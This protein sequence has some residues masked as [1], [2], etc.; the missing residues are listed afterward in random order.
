M[1][2]FEFSRIVFSIVLE[3]AVSFVSN[4]VGRIKFNSNHSWS[5]RAVSF[6]LD[7]S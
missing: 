4:I 1:I 7:L 2:V 3:K 6:G 5:S